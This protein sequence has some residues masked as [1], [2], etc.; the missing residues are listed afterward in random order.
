[1]ARALHIDAGYSTPLCGRGSPYTNK[2]TLER[3]AVTCKDCLKRLDAQ[4][5]AQS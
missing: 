3:S 2:V 4:Q 5:A 1:M